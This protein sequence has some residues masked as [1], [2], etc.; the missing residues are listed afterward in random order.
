MLK[1]KNN[2]TH[3]GQSGVL[4]ESQH[5]WC[6]FRLKTITYLSLSLMQYN[7]GVRTAY[8]SERSGRD[9]STVMRSNFTI[10]T[11]TSCLNCILSVIL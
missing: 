8:V 6:I 2:N 3:N 9:Q 5:F 10:D 1:K 11:H 7:L 4:I